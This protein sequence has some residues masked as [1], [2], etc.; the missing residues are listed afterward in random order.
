MASGPVIYRVVNDGS[1]HRVRADAWGPGA[2]EMIGG[3]ADLLGGRDR[4]GTFEAR[5]PL[6]RA[7]ERRLA[8]LRVPRTGLV[9]EA[10][11]PAVLHQKIQGRDAAHSWTWLV[12]RHGTPPP[13]TPG[14][15]AP[16]AM[17]VPPSPEGWAALPQWDWRRAGVEPAAVRTVRRAAAY[18]SR[19]DR[20]AAEAPGDPERVYRV[21]RAVPG[22]GPWT[23]AEVGH[24]ALGDADALSVGDYHLA[25]ITG[26]ALAGRSLDD[27]EAEAYLERWRPHR[28]RAMRLLELTPEA[29][30]PRRGPRMSRPQHRHGTG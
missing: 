3:L 27:A 11:V 23:A 24:R 28:Y 17:M 25:A 26:F 10:L 21:L 1:L 2:Q 7:A 19:L 30:P 6:L 15:T 18:A 5:H 4:P 29:W 14:A 16:P 20:L 8:G 9:F 13:P 12:R 22:V